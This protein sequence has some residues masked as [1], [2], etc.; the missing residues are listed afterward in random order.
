MQYAWFKRFLDIVLSLIALIVLAPFLLLF[1]FLIKLD[2]RGPIFY[3][4]E[5]V[6]RFG[7]TFRI[8]KFRT[9]QIGTPECSTEE[10]GDSNKYITKYGHFLR[11]FGIDELPQFINV[12]KGDMSIIGPRPVIVSETMLTKLRIKNGALAIRPGLSGW[13]QVNG[14]DAVSVSKKAYF[15]GHYAQN[16]G[17]FFDVSIF[18]LTIV[19]IFT[20]SGYKEGDTIKK[21]PESKIYNRF[22]RRMKNLLKKREQ[23]KKKEIREQKK[24]MREAGDT[25]MQNAYDKQSAVQDINIKQ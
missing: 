1:A 6:G 2:S 20:H 19:T 12:L 9:M 22:M 23:Q 4:Q 10:L 15:D 24:A 25:S 14:R 21:M 11:K 5:R 13:A 17:F 3:T 8:I 7:E 16:M 18:F